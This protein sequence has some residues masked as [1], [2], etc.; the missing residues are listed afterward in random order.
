MLTAVSKVSMPRRQCNIVEEAL[1]EIELQASGPLVR[2][3]HGV[4]VW[5]AVSLLLTAAVRADAMISP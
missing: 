4:S 2:S 5:Y 3:I 1:I